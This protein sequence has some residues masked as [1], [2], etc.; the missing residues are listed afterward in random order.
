MTNKE[1][2]RKLCLTLHTVEN[3]V[4]NLYFKTRAK[5]RRELARL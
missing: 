4:S 5:D 1:I 3:H 2:A